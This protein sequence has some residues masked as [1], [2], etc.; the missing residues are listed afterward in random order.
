MP[1]THKLLARMPGYTPRHIKSH[2]PGQLLPPQVWEKRVKIVYVVRNP[3]D[4]VVSLYHHA[5]MVAPVLDTEFDQVFEE[6]VQGASRWFLEVC[7]DLYIIFFSGMQ[8]VKVEALLFS[9]LIF[10]FADAYKS[11]YTTMKLA[12]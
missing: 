10:V 1:R 2:L 4:V 5:R 6:F 12:A 3:K 9:K 8:P 7:C 11:S